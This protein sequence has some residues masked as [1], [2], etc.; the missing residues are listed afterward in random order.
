MK[1]KMHDSGKKWN[2]RTKK[3]REEKRQFVS[4]ESLM[5]TDFFYWYRIKANYRDLDYIDFESGISESEVLE[6]MRTYYQAFDYY[7]LLLIGEINPALN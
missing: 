5:L 7:R 4:Q 6:Y 1:Y 3:G 2:L